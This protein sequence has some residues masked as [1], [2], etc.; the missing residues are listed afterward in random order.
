MFRWGGQLGEIDK[1]FKVDKIERRLY[2]LLFEPTS[3][4]DKEWPLDEPFPR[5]NGAQWIKERNGQ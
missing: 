2:S 4:K 1:V 5:L 3:I